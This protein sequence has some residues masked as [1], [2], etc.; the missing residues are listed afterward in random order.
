MSP[1]S[2]ALVLI[3]CRHKNY[4]ALKYYFVILDDKYIVY[5]FRMATLDERLKDDDYRHWVKAVLCLQYTKDGLVSLADR[6]S[7]ILHNA[8]LAQMRGSGNPSANGICT[9]ARI[10]LKKKTVICCSNCNAFLAET[11]KHCTGTLNLNN[12]DVTNLHDQPWQLA[13]LFMNP[14]Q[15]VTNTVPGQTDLSGILNFLDHCR[16][17]NILNTPN[18]KAVSYSFIL[19]KCLVNEKTATRKRHNPYYILH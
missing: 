1:C 9:P 11:K 16:Q 17:A 7:Q 13:K 18:I 15:D 5:F 2:L 12:S 14:G 6:T 8:V 19:V 4:A 3:M 10:D